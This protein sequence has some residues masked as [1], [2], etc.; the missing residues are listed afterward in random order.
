MGILAPDGCQQTSRPT[1][2]V[3]DLRSQSV[4][5]GNGSELIEVS[6]G[7][8]GRNMMI[9]PA[10]K[11]RVAEF[12]RSVGMTF[13]GQIRRVCEK[14]IEEFAPDDQFD[15]EVILQAAYNDYNAVLCADLGSVSEAPFYSR[16]E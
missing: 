15:P 8:P 4:L 12:L 5:G 13:G 2:D 9:S 14:R 16:L 3:T 10:E 7:L 6:E 11:E 1:R